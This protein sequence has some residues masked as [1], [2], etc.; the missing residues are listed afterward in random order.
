FRFA[1]IKKLRQ[2]SD[3]GISMGFVLN[4]VNT[5]RFAVVRFVSGNCLSGGTV[6]RNRG[7]CAFATEFNFQP[8]VGLLERHFQMR[9]LRRQAR[10]GLLAGGNCRRLQFRTCFAW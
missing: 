6:A 7:A 1:W 2:A 10:K 3:R 4:L 5:M 8:V 9:M